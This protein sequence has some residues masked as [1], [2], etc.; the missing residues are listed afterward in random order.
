MCGGCI[1]ARN[2]GSDPPV[3][4]ARAC[5]IYYPLANAADYLSDPALRNRIWPIRTNWYSLTEA[6]IR[7]VSAGK[8]NGFVATTGVSPD[9]GSGDDAAADAGHQ[10]AA[11]LQSRSGAIRRGRTGAESAARTR[12]G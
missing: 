9:P 10:A 8:P 3:H 2:S 7:P 11:A 4:A 6:R 1:S 12:C 5:R